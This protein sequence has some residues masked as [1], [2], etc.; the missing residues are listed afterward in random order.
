MFGYVTAN[1]K[2]LTPEQKQ[3]YKAIYCG[4]CGALKERCGALSRL[5]L[6]YDMAFLVML[7][8]SLYEPDCDICKRRCAMHPFRAG[9]HRKTENTLYA[10]DMTVILTYYKCL[11]DWNDDGSLLKR[12]YARALEAP[13][14]KA[15]EAHP[16]EA[17][18]IRGSLASLGAL[19][20][21]NGCADDAARCFGALTGAIFS[22]KDDFWREHLFAF[23]DALGQFIYIMDAWDDAPR[24][25]RR[26]SF[27][28]LLEDDPSSPGFDE[29]CRTILNHLMGRCA[30]EFE[31]LPLAQD[32][33][34][35]R[36]VIY[37]GIWTRFDMKTANKAQE[38]QKGRRRPNAG[39]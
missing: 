9:E 6:S 25:K 3:R 7:L 15:V 39:N 34:I 14:A 36:N 1:V 19:E 32:I 11:D 21:A 18:A 24:D 4:L 29:R 26:K 17:E 23:G 8:D 2:A 30:A 13:L 28:P 10:A 22:P 27:N 20:A 5:A 31:K 38:S 35:M 12:S 33:E 16:R 37:S